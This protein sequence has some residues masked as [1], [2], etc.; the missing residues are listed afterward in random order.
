MIS[1]SSS[2]PLDEVTEMSSASVGTT[3]T[4]PVK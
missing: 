3:T 4:E 2:D 1:Q